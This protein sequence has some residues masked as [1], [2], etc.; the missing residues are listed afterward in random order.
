M[1]NEWFV[2][3]AAV[4]RYWSAQNYAQPYEYWSAD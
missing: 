3:V 2:N 1:Q 4:E